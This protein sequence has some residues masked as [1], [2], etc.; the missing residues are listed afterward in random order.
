M[1]KFNFRDIV[2]L[3][4]RKTLIV[5][6]P[7]ILPFISS[8][9]LNYL[10]YL[11][12]KIYFGITLGINTSNFKIVKSE[13]FITSDSILVVESNRGAGFNLGIISNLKLGQYFDLRFVPTLSFSE[14]QL[15]YDML[16]N[17]IANKNIESIS[18]ELPVSIRFKSQPIKDIRIYVLTGLKY[19]MDMAS[20]ASKRKA[21]GQVKVSPHDLAY[22]VGL[23][24]QF[25]FP[26]FIFSPEV[27]ISNGILNV[28][29]R[30]EN[31]IF[32]NVLDKLFS[33]GLVISLHFE[34]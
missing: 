19:S 33:R 8:A 22:E 14:K 3:L 4:R 24:I 2:H 12:K 30:N 15:R 21:E 23:G 16:N 34:G 6:I 29:S 25:F 13:E 32:S 7:L 26:L 18:I 17:S 31:L 5:V 20:N 11:N 27:K 10:E 9:Q 1:Q 28:H